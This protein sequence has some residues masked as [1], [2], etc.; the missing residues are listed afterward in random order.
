MTV[1]QQPETTDSIRFVYEPTLEDVAEV[2]RTRRS[3]TSRGPR[4]LI[5][6]IAV[7]VLVAYIVVQGVV[8]GDFLSS[9]LP[10]LILATAIT[11]L[12]LSMRRVQARQVFKMKTNRGPHTIT[13]DA[14]GVH[15]AT[16]L[17]TLRVPWSDLSGYTETARLFVLLH[18][19]MN[20]IN[21]LPLPK[22]ALPQ[23]TDADRLRDLLDHHSTR[24]KGARKA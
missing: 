17:S 5:P 1:D 11:A 24:V 12:M 23:P 7:L 10:L 20:E 14:K 16:A 4:K 3:V 19:G 15:V 18:R 13:L 6:L 21:T 9:S 22:S 8:D 2:L